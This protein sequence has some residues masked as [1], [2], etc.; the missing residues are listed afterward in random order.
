MSCG[1]EFAP[2]SVRQCQCIGC[3]ALGRIANLE[4]EAPEALEIDD[5]YELS[6]WTAEDAEYQGVRRG[7]AEAS[8]IA[9]HAFAEMRAKDEV[10][11]K[12]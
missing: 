4:E 2:T 12:G 3:D 7:R 8:R 1:Q 9:R 10:Q 6:D 5:V 11:T